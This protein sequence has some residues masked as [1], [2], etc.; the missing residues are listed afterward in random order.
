M[1]CLPRIVQVCAKT[2]EPFVERDERRHEQGQSG[3]GGLLSI[4]QGDVIS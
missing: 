1:Q 2:D 3:R 4:R